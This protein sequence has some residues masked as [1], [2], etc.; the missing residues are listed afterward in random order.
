LI[1][2]HCNF[3]LPGLLIGQTVH[4]EAQHINRNSGPNHPT[5][6]QNFWTSV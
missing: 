4:E 6:L 2:K 5:A 3:F 1:F